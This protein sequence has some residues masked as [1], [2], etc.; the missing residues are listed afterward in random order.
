V[1]RGLR[2]DG[3]A[4]ELYG[5]IEAIVEAPFELGEGSLDV[6]RAKG[7]MSSNAVKQFHP[8]SL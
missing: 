2:R 3:G 6:L 1:R 4:V 5:E 7:P 8:G